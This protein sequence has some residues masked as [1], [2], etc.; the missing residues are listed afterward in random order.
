MSI[1]IP[2]APT[3]DAAPDVM[4]RLAALSG[5]DGKQIEERLPAGHP[6]IL[7]A[8]ACVLSL[9]GILM[10]LATLVVIDAP[11]SPLSS[12]IRSACDAVF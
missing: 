4:A 1:D 8:A 11:D 3:H 5:G 2:P 9:L 6:R 10:L 7:P 12:I